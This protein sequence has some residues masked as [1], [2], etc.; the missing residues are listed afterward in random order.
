MIE[1]FRKLGKNPIIKFVMLVLVVAFMLSGVSAGFLAET[2][3]DSIVKVAGTKIYPQQVQA[4]LRQILQGLERAGIPA[5][6]ESLKQLGVNEQRIVDE[7]IKKEL[8]LAEIK[9]LGLSFSD[10]TVLENIIKSPQFERNGKFDKE[11]L[12]QYLY[13]KGLREHQYI[14]EIRN[15]LA[16]N[17]MQEVYFSELSV[18]KQVSELL[19]DRLSTRFDFEAIEIPADY[20][21]LQGKASDEQLKEFHFS[22]SF[23]FEVPETRE[24][25]YIEIPKENNLQELNNK[26]N[27]IEDELAGGA[28]LAEIAKKHSLEVQKTKL[29]KTDASAIAAL[30]AGLEDGETSEAKEAADSEKIAY[31]IATLDKT[32]PAYV[33]ELAK[34]RPQVE[35]AYAKNQAEKLTLQFA[36]DQ[37]D[38][39]GKVGNFSNI[40]KALSIK[41]MIGISGADFAKKGLQKIS[42]KS[43]IDAKKGEVFGLYE[44]YAKPEDA[45]ATSLNII[46]LVGKSKISLTD[47]EIKQAKE[48]LNASYS[49]EIDTAF[50][51]Y[52]S[53]KHGVVFRKLDKKEEAK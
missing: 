46:R 13:S 39:L 38:K 23:L 32:T 16:A 43:P 51:K 26:V 47:A 22:N 25:S 20:V 19:L 42:G 50:L 6:E 11:L 15:E 24:I 14:E 4:Q 10:D 44:F 36:L 34:I 48:G 52:L 28:T 35:S 7:M 1:K 29:T 9:N 3:D 45:K 2:R 17:L 40:D 12:T 18:P 8:I 53:K 27:G 41:K 30:V 21:Q 49:Q 33:P 37:Y 31:R 5:T